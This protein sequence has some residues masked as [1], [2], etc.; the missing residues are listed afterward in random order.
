MKAPCK[1]SLADP[2]PSSLQTTLAAGLSHRWSTMVPHLP[3]RRTS[4]RPSP[5]LGP[6]FSRTGWTRQPRRRPQPMHKVQFGF[7]MPHC[8]SGLT[9][10]GYGAWGL[11]EEM[12]ANWGPATHLTTA[13]RPF[14]Q[15]I[16][17]LGIDSWAWHS[18]R[19][20]S[21]PRQ[22]TFSTQNPFFFAMRLSLCIERKFFH[23]TSL[24]TSSVSSRTSEVSQFQDGVMK[25]TVISYLV[26]GSATLVSHIFL[27]GNKGGEEKQRWFYQ[28]YLRISW[29]HQHKLIVLIKPSSPAQ[30]LRYF[31]LCAISER[32]TH[33]GLP[34]H[35]M[36]LVTT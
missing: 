34:P 24:K 20:F 33:K 9:T 1:A 31:V 14:L 15:G 17:L 21:L 16:G 23:N 13:C 26:E 36:C 12:R 8:H 30:T 35:K 25:K 2:K 7:N 19:E 10:T 6:A 32:A 28:I 4:T 3:S 29:G 18:D 22:W 11:P 27:G 5:S